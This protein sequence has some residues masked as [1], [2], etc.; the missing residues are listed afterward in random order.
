LEDQIEQLEKEKVDTFDLKMEL[1]LI[2][3]K[4]MTG[5]FSVVDIYLEGLTPRVSKEWEKIGKK[6]KKRQIL[7]VNEEEVKESIEEA[8]KAREK[9]AK[10]EKKTEEKKAEEK[11]S[12]DKKAE[13]NGEEKKSDEKK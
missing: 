4:V 8:K 9:A 6:P 3:D 7:L 13:N 11:Q 12:E 10:E 1:K 5:N 2:K